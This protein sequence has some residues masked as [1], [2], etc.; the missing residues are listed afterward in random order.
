MPTDKIGKHLKNL[1][2]D[3]RGQGASS[4]GEKSCTSLMSFRKENHPFTFNLCVYFA[5]GQ[6]SYRQHIVG[7]C[8]VIQS[9]MLCFLIGA[10][11]PLTF[12][13]IIDKYLYIAIVNLVFQLIM[14]LLCS[15]LSLVG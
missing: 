12:K 3:V 2:S 1:E 5:L 10:F 13:V 8:F 9:A 15:F 11:S 6:V 14:L 7:S 4:T